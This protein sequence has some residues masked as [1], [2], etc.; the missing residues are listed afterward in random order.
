MVELIHWINAQGW[1]PAT[2]TNYSLRHPEQPDLCLVSR[3]GVD[4]ALFKSSDLLLMNRQGQQVNS[5]TPAKSSAETAIHL[6]LFQQTDCQAILHTHSLADTVLSRHY[7][8]QGMIRLSDYELLKGLRGITSHDH[9]I[10]IPI[11]PNTQ[12]IDT[13]SQ[14]VR[15]RLR[16][17]P[18][19]P[20]FLIAGHGLYTWGKSLAEAKR[21]LEV[22]QFLFN[23]EL[24]T[25]KIAH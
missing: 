24:E 20:G 12:D 16:E 7:A 17:T 4:K 8:G 18:A 11:F 21:H 10:E 23:C 19:L 22:F 5:E 9:C 6:M 14:D 1:S 15:Q 3:S 25:L 13:L 2:S